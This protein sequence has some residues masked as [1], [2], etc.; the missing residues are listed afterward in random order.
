MPTQNL[1]PIS[2]VIQNIQEF[3]ED[4]CEQQITIR[5]SDGIHNFIIGLA[6]ISLV[7]SVCETV[8][9]SQHSMTPLSQS[10]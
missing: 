2:G 6:P 7:K 5:N 10:P 9:Q 4:C 1:V 8:C 3:S